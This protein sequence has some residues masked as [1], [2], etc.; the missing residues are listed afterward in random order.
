VGDIDKPLL[1]I[2]AASHV[3]RERGR[4]RSTKTL[5]TG[6]AIKRDTPGRPRG[7]VELTDDLVA[8]LLGEVAARQHA[9]EAKGLSLSERRALYEI[10]VELHLKRGRPRLIAEML[11]RDRIPALQKLLSRRRKKI[12]QKSE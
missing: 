6:A 11:T 4:P 9:A 5:L 12:A 10:G 7:R 1:F 2:W 8:W 3:K